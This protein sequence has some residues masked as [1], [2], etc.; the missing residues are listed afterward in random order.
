MVRVFWVAI[1]TGVLALNGL[2][3][4]IWHAEQMGFYHH[5]GDA[6]LHQPDSAANSR[7]ASVT[8]EHQIPSKKPGAEVS[9]D[10]LHPHQDAPVS[11]IATLIFSHTVIL[12]PEFSAPLF[13]PLRST[14]LFRPP[15]DLNS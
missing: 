5:H 8:Q 15:R 6:I 3:H 13:F 9:L 2:S 10:I 12:A 1:L 14:S 4:L 7:L 11:S